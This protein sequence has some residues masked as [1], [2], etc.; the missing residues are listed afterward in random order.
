MTSGREPVRLKDPTGFITVVPYLPGSHPALSLFALIVDAVSGSIVAT[1]RLDLS[2]PGTHSPELTQHLGRIMGG[3]D[4]T[5]VLL[6]GYGPGQNV[7]PIMADVRGI[8]PALGIEIIDALRVDEGHYWFYLCGDPEC[9]PVEGTPFGSR[10]SVAARPIPLSAYPAR[11]AT[12]PARTGRECADGSP[13]LAGGRRRH[14][15][16]VRCD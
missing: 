1:I 5:H 12:A 4:V 13:G 8:L 7:T 6:I 16:G 10:A 15:R 3:S 14:H 9:C 2:E 11:R